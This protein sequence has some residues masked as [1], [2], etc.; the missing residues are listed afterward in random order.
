MSR[1]P[2]IAKSLGQSHEKKANVILRIVL[3]GLYINSS[4]LTFF[5]V[6]YLFIDRYLSL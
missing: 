2:N 3:G 6:L 5:R 1:Y 4:E